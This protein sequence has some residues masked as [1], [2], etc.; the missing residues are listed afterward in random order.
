MKKARV[1]VLQGDEWQIEGDLVL[2]ER[3]VYVIK[4]ETLRVKI[5]QLH[6]EV[7]V[8]RY[9]GRWKTTELVT[10]N[11]WWPGV[12]RDVGKYVNSCDMCQKM[13]NMME[14]PAEKL[15]LSEIPEKSQMYLMVD[16][17][18]KLLLVVGKD[19]ILVVCHRLSK[20]H[21]FVATITN[22]IQLVSPQPVD[23]FS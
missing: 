6:H 4:G 17:I 14:A 8:V 12:M 10:R 16:F 5:I 3:K 22:F 1:E 21:Y 11:Y 9:K 7:L 18:T 19:V 13:K 20:I 15:K 23:L 2:K